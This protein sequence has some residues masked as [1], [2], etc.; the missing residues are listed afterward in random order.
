MIIK[1]GVVFTTKKWKCIDIT[2]YLKIFLI[3][4][5]FIIGALIYSIFT[6]K[7]IVNNT[8]LIPQEVKTVIIREN[9]KFSISKFK[10]E[11]KR[12]RIKFPDIV[13]KQ[14]L[15][16]SNNFKSPIF[17]E[18]NN[19]FGMKL[20]RSRITTAIGVKRNHACYHTWR[21][22]LLDYALYQ[23]AYL[24]DIKT[25]DEYLQYLGKYYAEDSNYLNKLK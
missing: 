6:K 15:L 18:N 25:K 24:R 21:D 12:L 20:A 9:N 2:S 23:E 14:A 13:Y 4:F 19:M 11:L 22:C 3:L 16:E 17:K 5:L 1:N 8:K 10:T 7:I